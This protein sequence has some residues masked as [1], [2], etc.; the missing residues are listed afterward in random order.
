M[1]AKIIMWKTLN[2]RYMLAQ[3][4]TDPKE[5]S[6]TAAMVHEADYLPIDDDTCLVISDCGEFAHILIKSGME[7]I[8]VIEVPE[9]F[10]K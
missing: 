7:I 8:N 4:N 9:D 2:Y 5:K 3:L 1:N 6:D 10:I